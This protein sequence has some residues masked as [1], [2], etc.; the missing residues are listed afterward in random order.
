MVRYI[1]IWKTAG[2]RGESQS[3]QS[4]RTDLGERKRRSKEGQE[5]D[6]TWT[7]SR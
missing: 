5:I 3:R 2:F 4:R 6:A 1:Y 7:H